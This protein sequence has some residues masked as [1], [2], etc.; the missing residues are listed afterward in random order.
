LPCS[1]GISP[2]PARHPT[3]Y[4]MTGCGPPPG[5]GL[6]SSCARVAHN[7]FGSYVCDSGIFIPCA[8]NLRAIAFASPFGLPHSY[9]P[10]FLIQEERWYTDHCASLR[11]HILSL[12]HTSFLSCTTCVSPPSFR[13]FQSHACGFFSAFSHD[14]R[15]LS[16]YSQY[17]GFGFNG[18]V[19][20][21]YTRKE[22]LFAATS[23]MFYLRGCHSL[24][25]LFPKRSDRIPDRYRSTT[26]PSILQCGIQYALC[27]FQS[28]Y[29]PHRMLFLFL[30]VLRYFSSP[31][32]LALSAKFSNP[33]F[34]G[35]L[36]PTPGLSQLATTFLAT[37]A[38]PSARWFKLIYKLSSPHI[39]LSN[40]RFH[41]VFLTA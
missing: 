16:V 14:T 23:E 25:P 27:G 4:T 7:G 1:S 19:F 13:S 10:W 6:A 11:I 37:I 28:L 2:L 33:G 24:W 30:R 40:E 26:S 41:K 5:V 12:L 18:P 38:K 15:S 21:P 36:A 20:A 32:L 35:R 34:K 17:L 31:R 29:L 9:T 39:H 22:L 8:S 3:G